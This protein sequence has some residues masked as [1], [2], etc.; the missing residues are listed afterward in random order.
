[1]IK[2]IG[3]EFNTV[4]RSVSYLVN[5]KEK[6]T[7]KRKGQKKRIKKGKEEKEGS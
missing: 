3:G 2:W 1:M 5:T 7:K 4:N 6:E